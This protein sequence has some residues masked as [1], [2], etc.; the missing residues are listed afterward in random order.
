M[1]LLI[2]YTQA[3]E[4]HRRAATALYNYLLESH[5]E[6]EIKL[7]DT[8]DYSSLLFR[9]VYN[10]LYTLCITRMP[11]I[12]AGA[13][14]LS[15]IRLMRPVIKQ[16]RYFVNGFNTAGFVKFLSEYRPDAVVV[17]HFLPSAV[18]SCLREKKRINTRLISVITDYNVHP[19]WLTS[20]TDIYT[21]PCAYARDELIADNVPPEKIKITGIP[22]DPKF[23]AKYDKGEIRLKLG[24]PDKRFT[25]LLATSGFGIGPIEKIADLLHND[26]QLLVV[27][28]RNEKLYK[29]LLSKNYPSAKI[30][31]FVN[32]MEELMA[33]CDIFITKPGG[34]TITE[35]LTMGTPMM[36]ISAIP[37]QETRNAAI[38]AGYGV[39]IIP[40]DL[41]ALKKDILELKKDPGKLSLMREKV[42]RIRKPL[43]SKE[44]S[45][46]FLPR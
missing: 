38:M 27:C 6:L 2:V 29:K 13:Y 14:H 18:I 34:M 7:I 42:S 43:A 9:S 40:E 24:I 8:L 23:T 22:V 44:I 45:E 35:S 19:F 46:C 15:R 41:S 1:R 4:G 20:A 3:G 10:Q 11:W 36:F 26:V 12:W 37:G 31:G 28:G 39:A 25:V 16:L 5:K 30:F 21:A 32:N 33:S 17:T